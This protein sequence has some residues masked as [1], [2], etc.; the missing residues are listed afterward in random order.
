M[1]HAFKLIANPPTGGFHVRAG[2][3]IVD[4]NVQGNI[5]SLFV[6]GLG[7]T[8]AWNVFFNTF[9]P[10]VLNS[11]A[12]LP[13]VRAAAKTVTNTLYGAVDADSVDRAF[14]AVGVGNGC[15]AV[16]QSPVLESVHRC[17][18]WLLR[19]PPVAGATVYHGQMN[20]VIW[21]WINATTIVDGNATQCTQTVNTEYHA[22]VRACNGCGC[23]NWSNEVLMD[24]WPQCP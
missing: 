14:L 17:P 5:P 8:K 13:Q 7:P 18:R 3:P 15:S 2:Q 6:A 4:S 16:P 22:R 1:S 20:P 21:Q 11:F 23:S 9:A 19:W 10:G 24:Y 12:T